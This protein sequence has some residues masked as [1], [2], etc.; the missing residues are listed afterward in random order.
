MLKE[1]NG[2]KNNR[3]NGTGHILKKNTVF[4][5]LG[6]LISANKRHSVTQRDYKHGT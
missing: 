4:T 6:A 3:N 2:E 1:N 5:V